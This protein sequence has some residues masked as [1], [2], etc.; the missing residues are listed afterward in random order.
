MKILTER[1][2]RPI[3]RNEVWEKQCACGLYI[4]DEYRVCDRCVLE[5]AGTL[6]VL[7]VDHFDMGETLYTEES[8][9]LALRAANA[10]EEEL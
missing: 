7:R 1:G 4:P 3:A 5:R 6:L 9:A 8:V 2:L 10:W